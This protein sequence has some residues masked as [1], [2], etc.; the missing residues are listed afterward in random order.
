MKVA[1][2][3]GPGHLEVDFPDNVTVVQPRPQPGLPDERAALLSALDAPIG[4]EPLREWLSPGCKVCI[5]FPDITRAMPNTRVLPWLLDYLHRHGVRDEQVVLLNS[6]GTHR[7]NTPEE[8]DRMLGKAI[9]ARYRVV[10]HECEDYAN[11]VQFGVTSS[12]AVSDVRV[13]AVSLVVCALR[14]SIVV[15]TARSP[16]LSA[17]VGAS[18]AMIRDM[19]LAAC[20][21]ACGTSGEYASA[22]NA[23]AR[24]A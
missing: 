8:L 23:S 16:G 14:S 22:P 18:G 15:S 21:A 24:P 13:G 20:V 10:N 4:C 19:T 5:I 1:L 17:R 7:P 9:T 12:G 3:Y 11:M 6:T 2:A